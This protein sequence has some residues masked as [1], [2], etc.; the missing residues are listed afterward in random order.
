[1]AAIGLLALRLG[2]GVVFAYHGWGKLQAMDQTIGF[3]GT[4]GI[5]LASFFAWLVALVEFLGGIAIILG[6]FTKEVA[7][8]LAVVMIVA[9][10]T[11][12]INQPFARAEL[13]IALLGGSLALAGLGAGPWRLIKKESC[14]GAKDKK[15]DCCGGS[16]KS[17]HKK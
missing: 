1:M 12:H 17:D 9:L 8:V 3:F 10:L 15:D 2:L 13:A 16:C 5:P 4:L 11:A 6:I 7:K 14:C